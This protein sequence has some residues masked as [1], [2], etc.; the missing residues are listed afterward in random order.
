MN[1]K[2]TNNGIFVSMISILTS[3]QVVMLSSLGSIRSR[4]ILYN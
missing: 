2:D 1:H 3:L 4:G